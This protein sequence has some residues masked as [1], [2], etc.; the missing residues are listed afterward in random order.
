MPKVTQKDAVNFLNRQ[1]FETPN[2]LLDK[3]ILSK[4]NPEQGVEAIK[5]IQEAAL[6]S[7]LAGDRAVRLIETG[8]ASTANYNL[9]EL[10]SDLRSGIWSELKSKKTI[11]IY[12]RNLQKVFVEKVTSLL[13]PGMAVSSYIPQGATYGFDSRMVDLKKTDLPSIARAHLES[14]KGE[15]KAALPLTTDKMSKYHLQDVLQRIEIAL[16]PNK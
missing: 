7:L 8:S 13:N 12:R 5:T 11:D 10:M 9:D 1:V 16:N 3:N 4:I 14:L 6:N 2:W 15:I